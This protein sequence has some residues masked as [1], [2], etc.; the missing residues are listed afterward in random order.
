MADYQDSLNHATISSILKDSKA[1]LERMEKSG[2]PLTDGQS[3]ML[4]ELRN[5]TW[6]SGAPLK[7]GQ[8]ITNLL[9]GLTLAANDE[10]T[11]FFNLVKTAA[12][13]A[14][15]VFKKLTVGYN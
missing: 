13:A 6:T 12:S 10:I 3:K 4:Y 5:T 2:K 8:H 1:E 14:G 7:F 9:S 11:V 15:L